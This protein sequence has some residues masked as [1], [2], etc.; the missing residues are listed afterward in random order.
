MFV[1]G[2]AG[3]SLAAT[4]TDLLLRAIQTLEMLTPGKRKERI[5]GKWHYT[6]LLDTSLLSQFPTDISITDPTGCL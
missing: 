4:T 1:F 2:F 3:N 6:P 5:R